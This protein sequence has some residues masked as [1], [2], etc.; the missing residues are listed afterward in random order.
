MAAKMLAQGH[1]VMFYENTDGGHA[2][3]AN[4]KQSAEMWAL[5][6]VYLREKLGLGK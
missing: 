3:A 6:F 2:A 5:S 4:H 1:D